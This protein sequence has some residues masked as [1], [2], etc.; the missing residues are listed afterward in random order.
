MVDIDSWKV[1]G[2]REAFLELARMEAG[3]KVRLEEV[4]VNMAFPEAW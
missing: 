2:E 1:K 3:H 4:F